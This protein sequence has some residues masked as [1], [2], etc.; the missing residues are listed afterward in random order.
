MFAQGQRRARPVNGGIKT[1]VNGNC[2][3]CFCLLKI[4]FGEFK[5]FHAKLFQGLLE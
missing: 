3:L 5:Y 2:S 4:K 1:S